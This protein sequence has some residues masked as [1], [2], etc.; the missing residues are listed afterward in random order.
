VGEG[1]IGGRVTHGSGEYQ[2]E[3]DVW[4]RGISVGE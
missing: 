1:Y 3:S 4:K 2:W